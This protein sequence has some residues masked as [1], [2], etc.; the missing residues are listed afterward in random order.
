M[1]TVSLQEVML[2]KFANR[3][4]I[5]EIEYHADGA[6]V[7]I[8]AISPACRICFTGEKGGGIQIGQECMCNCP[9]C[10][11]PRDRSDKHHNP[12]MSSN[13]ILVDFFKHS[14]DLNWLP[15]SY[16]FQSSGETLSY[17]D[18][19][20]QFGPLFR[21]YEKKTGIKI[22][23]YLYSNGILI[24]EEMID[25]L[26]FLQIQEIRFHLSAS[27]FSEKVFRNMELAYKSGITVSVEE[28][29]MPHRKETLLSH[30]KTFEELH[31][32][33]LNLV[34][35][36]ITASNKPELD[37]LYPTGRMYK[38]H[39]YHVYDEGMVYDIMR[40][41]VSNKYQYS[42]LDCNSVVENHRHKKNAILG[43]DMKTIDG[44]CSPFDRRL[45]VHTQR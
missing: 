41:V 23:H 32:T 4:S 37:K 45:Y 34:E 1:R 14:L 44:M 21:S 3:N 13:S 29:S 7:H 40:E 10:Y 27:N 11:Y 28:P 22:Y 18:Y 15:R 16:A 20:L 36:Q 9:E 6:C 2:E 12:E 39:F 31:V 30:L 43:M 42:V 5:P 17:I 19:M 24:D 38:D 33:H 8:G 26:K 25:K 35:V